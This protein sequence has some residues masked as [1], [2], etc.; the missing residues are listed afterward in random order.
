[1]NPEQRS[2]IMIA[3]HDHTFLDQLADRLLKMDM[4]VD[5]A[6]NGKT[7]IQLIDSESYDLIVTEIAMPI[8]NGLEILRKAKEQN[9]YVPILITSFSATT[10]WAEQAMREGAHA[11]LLRPLKR[12]N[13]FD[14]AVEEALRNRQVPT[15]DHSFFEQVFSKGVLDETLPTQA[16]IPVP[17]WELELEPS[18]NLGPSSKQAQAQTSL[19]EGM[20]ELNLQGQILNCNPAARKWLML[21]ANLP[22]RPIKRF[23]KTLGDSST[24]GNAELQVDGRMVHLITSKDRDQRGSECIILR[25]REVGKQDAGFPES[26]VAPNAH[27]HRQQSARAESAVAFGGNIKKY[28]PDNVDQGWSPLL[29]ID[30][31][32]RNIKDEVE[33]IKV[34]NPLRIFEQPPE[35]ADPEVVITMSRRLSDVSRGR[36]SSF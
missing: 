6:E 11:F 15:P 36:R 24:L 30:E 21:E 22:E 5:F 16:D 8:Y 31:V 25:I 26:Q 34:N 17:D 9:P 32:K 4:E 33:R 14:V 20:I 3:D 29:F 23:I 2:R 7:A 13:E 35:E 19:P 10:E 12:M 28:N 1:M 27:Q 18:A